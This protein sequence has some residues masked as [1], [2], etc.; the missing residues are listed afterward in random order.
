[1]AFL[2]NLCLDISTLWGNLKS[3]DL[4]ILSGWKVFLIDMHNLL[5]IEMTYSANKTSLVKKV[6]PS[7]CRGSL[8]FPWSCI[9]AAAKIWSDGRTSVTAKCNS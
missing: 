2:E 5:K 6:C 3:E 7:E 9:F 4:K 1:M 8:Y